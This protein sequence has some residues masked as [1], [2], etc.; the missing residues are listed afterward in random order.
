[1][2]ET[3][4]PPL[5]D[6]E[7]VACNLCGGDSARLL[8]ALR[9]HRL[10]VDDRTW[11]LVRCRG[12][13]LGWLAPRPTPEAIGRYYPDAYYADREAGARFAAQAEYLGDTPGDL[14]DVGCAGGEFLRYMATRGWRVAGL[15][16][17]ADARVPGIPIARRWDDPALADGA[18]DAVTAWSVFEH[19]HQPD[20][21]F[22]EAARVLRPGGRLVV[23]VPN[24]RSPRSRLARQE[25]VPRHLYFFTAR[26]LRAYGGRAGLKLERVSHDTRVM[27]GSPGTFLRLHAARLLGRSPDQFLDWAATND[28]AARRQAWPLGYSV[29]APLAAVERLALPA[30]VRRRLHLNGYVIAVFV[31]R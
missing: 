14:L 9:D 6:E 5:P 17:H 11:G 2:I 26:T 19:V 8:Y 24:L 4:R 15:E 31:R 29:M 20:E 21:Y 25:D 7:V 10:H 28:R 27:D 3:P 16:P 18:F 22:R 23:H 30:P 13:G 1:L 12:C